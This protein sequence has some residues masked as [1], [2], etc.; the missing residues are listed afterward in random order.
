MHLNT[1]APARRQHVGRLAERDLHQP[2]S[3][4]V[5]TMMTQYRSTLG[6][7]IDPYPTDPIGKQTIKG[8]YRRPGD[9]S[10]GVDSLVANSIPV[11]ELDV[12]VVDELGKPTRRLAIR[13]EPGTTRGAIIGALVGAC[14]GAL[15]VALVFLGLLGESWIDSFGPNIYISTLALICVPAVAGVPIGA[16]IGMGHWQG[17]K[18]ISV[19]EIQSGGVIVVVQTDELADVAR[20]VLR[21][22][23]AVDVTG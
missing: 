13:D 9:V 5:T 4:T 2:S 10:R 7:G 22:T 6:G 15:M 19:P 1:A 17:R 23:G 12:Y 21:D 18:R 8:L 16:V 11:D 20:R 3:V 14:L